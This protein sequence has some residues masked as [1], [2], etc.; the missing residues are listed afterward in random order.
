MHRSHYRYFANQ[1]SLTNHEIWTNFPYFYHE[2]KQKVYS[3]HCSYYA[4]NESQKLG[5]CWAPGKWSEISVNNS[6]LSKIFWENCEIRYQ[7][8]KSKR[9]AEWDVILVVHVIKG[10][11]VLA[12]ITSKSSP[13]TLC[14]WLF[15]R[16]ILKSPIT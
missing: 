13:V 9:V 10:K 7:Y 6:P 14:D 12:Y 3:L 2:R 1:Y 5:K 16:F 8:N 15:I 11:N 4:H